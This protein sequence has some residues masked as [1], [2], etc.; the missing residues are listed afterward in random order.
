MTVRVASWEAK[1][2]RSASEAARTVSIPS[3]FAARTIRSAISPRFAMRSRLIDKT[4]DLTLG[5]DQKK[6][7]ARLD[8]LRV[9]GAYFAEDSGGAGSQSRKQFHD[10]Q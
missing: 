4:I 7:V 1:L 6:N 3:E 8:Q 9:N 10:F 2:P 5:F